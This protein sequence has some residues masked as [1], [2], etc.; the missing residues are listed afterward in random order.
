LGFTGRD[1]L[2]AA[3]REALTSGDQAVVQALRGMGGVGK[4][5]LAIEYTHRY[6]PE[7]DVVWWIAAA[8]PELIGGQFAA[9][10]TALGCIQP[11]AEHAAVRRAVLGELRGRDR[12]LL[13]FDN[14]EQSDEI[15]GWLPG[16]AGHVLITSRAGGWEELAVSVEVDVLERG[17][18][19]AMLRRRVP[20][21]GEAGAGLV[22]AAVGDL[23]LAVAQAAS[24]MAPTGI[25]GADYVQMVEGRAADIL[26]AGRPTSYPLS[27]AAVTQLAMDR[28]EAADAAAAQVVR[29]CAFLAPEPVPAEWFTSAA[30]TR[31]PGALRKA[32]ADP[33]AWGQVMTRISGQALARVDQQ[34]LLMHRLTQAIIRSRL[35]LDDADTVRAQ[36]AALLTASEPGKTNLPG[37]WPEWAR[38]LPHLLALDPG[39][40][41]EGLSNLTSNAIWYLIN[42]GLARNAHELA[43]RLYQ[44]RLTEHG[45]NGRP[46]LD[47]ATTLAAVLASTGHRA[48]ARSI[49]EDTLA[50]CRLVLGKDH[51]RTL[52]SA[53]NLAVDLY[54]LGEYQAARELAEDTLARRRRILGEG[55]PDTLA[56]ASNLAADLR[57]LGEYQAARNLNKDTLIRRRRVLGEDHPDTIISRLGLAADLRALGEYREALDLDKDSLARSRRVLGEDHPDT[58]TSARTLAAD[59]RALGQYRLAMDL[60]EDTLPRSRRVLGEDHPDTLRTARSLAASLRALGDYRAARDLD[61][62]SLARIRVVLGD[63]HPDTLIS[64]RNLAADLLA[65]GEDSVGSRTARPKNPNPQASR[66]K[67]SRTT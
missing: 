26:D 24:Y 48:E 6:A 19:I 41:I 67:K 23:P 39:A 40:R 38:L 60:D 3:V 1:K 46:T 36:A 63:D 28:L 7:Y 52:I 64:A 18:S 66:K 45:P 55:H 34:G 50:R 53:S 12:W 35:S 27:L 8:R 32:T 22:A 33:L 21:L 17:E 59:L 57:E 2:L 13:V 30:A 56:S 54:E 37:N 47:A 20:G 31:L 44:S 4:T 10:G 43:R 9:L 29:I 25:S 15:T 62:D 16:G 61:E 14:A 11:G 49:D 42:C 65:L 58:L 5:Q 51:S